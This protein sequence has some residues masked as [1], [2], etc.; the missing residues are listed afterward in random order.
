MA[1]SWRNPWIAAGLIALLAVGAAALPSMGWTSALAVLLGLAGVVL[2][3]GNV[4]RSGALLF[5][6]VAVAVGLLDLFAGLLAPA[7]HGVGLVKTAEPVDWLMPDPDLGYSP[8]PDTKVVATST[9]DGATVFR[10]TYTIDDRGTR[11][12]PPAPAGADTYLF[13]GESFMF[14]QGV[15]DDET[16][17]AQFARANDG[18]VRTINFSAPGYAPNQLVRAVETGRLDFLKGEPIKAAVTWIIPADM[19]RVTGDES[20]LAS[21]PRYRLEDGVPRFTGSFSQYRWS[22]PLAGLRYVAD[23]NFPFIAAIGLQQRQEAQAALFSALLVRLQQLVRER[24][25]APLLVLYSWPDET[26]PANP[27]EPVETR[28]ALVKILAGLRARGLS[29]M[30]AEKPTWGNDLSKIVIP[31]DGH[32]TA[33]ANALVATALKERLLAP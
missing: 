24:L 19:S 6:A 5:A 26:T 9:Y 2:L 11:R 21:S 31:H 17:P 8:R 28:K 30:S 10:V 14:G 23:Q 18:K 25:N 22:H 27:G 29:L 20:W 32:P 13:L 3:H 15:G 4:W 12:S 7:A 1:G 16:L 33:F